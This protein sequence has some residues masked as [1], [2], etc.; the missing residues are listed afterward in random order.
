MPRKARKGRT[1]FGI[2]QHLSVPHKP[3]RQKSP[4]S[5]GRV[6]VTDVP[7][8]NH[9]RTLLIVVVASVIIVAGSVGY[10]YGV[11]APAKDCVHSSGDGLYL[12]LVS[13]TTGSSLANLTVKGQLVMSCQPSSG[14]IQTL[15]TWN[16]QT[17]GTGFVSVPSSDLSGMGFWFTFTYGGSTYLAKSPVCGEGVTYVQLNLP[18]GSLS[19]KEVPSTNTGVVVSQGANGIQT[20]TGCNAIN[21]QGNATIS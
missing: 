15:G 12:H 18:S 4:Q 19:G 11:Y 3:I 20:T 8:G 7:R 21:W 2:A 1:H 17:N 6:L 13:N 10:Y 14:N 9:K 5:K 16:F